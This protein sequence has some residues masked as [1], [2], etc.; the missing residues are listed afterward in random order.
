[1]SA[2]RPFAVIF[3]LGAPGA[4]K[5]TICSHLGETYQL[6]HYSVG[7]GLRSW[8]RENRTSPLAV[9]IQDKLDNQ[10]FLSSDDLNPFIEQAIKDALTKDGPKLRGI[11]V[12]GFPRCVE[13]LETFDSWPF[14]D[15]LPLAAPNGGDLGVHPKP[16]I[17]VC[18]RITKQNAEARYLGR[19]RD[20]N[21]SREKFQR[22]FAEYE[23]ETM[24]V[25][26]AYRDRGVLIELDVNGTKE[27]NLEQTRKTLRASGL[28]QRIM[29]EG[30]F[31]T[32][33]VLS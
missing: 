23:A 17:V 26:D 22:R 12:D 20:S 7:D 27:E 28:W 21:D 18:L 15:Q 2:T 3:V 29:V 5:G 8:M 30:Q 31:S 14:Q 13:Q 9:Q 4:G 25:E 10:G 19:G 6:S 1:M 33:F 16:N 32:Q 11:L 24:A